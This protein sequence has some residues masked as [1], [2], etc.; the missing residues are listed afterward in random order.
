MS[1]VCEFCGKTPHVGNNVSHANNKTKRI[2]YPNLQQVRHV[3][4]DGSVRRVR[5]CTRC[6][7]SGRVIKPA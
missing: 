6:I 4:Q 3:R 1:R 5:A 2:W 7:R